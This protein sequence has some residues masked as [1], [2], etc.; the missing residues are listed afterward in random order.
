MVDC[1]C[2]HIGYCDGSCQHPKPPEI[3]KDCEVCCGEGQILEG[4][5]VYEE[6][7]GFSHPD[8]YEKPCLACNG[9]G[10]F[11]CEAEGEQ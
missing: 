7:C 10:V 4:I 2:Q 3:W 6:G 9:A 8:V 5:H 11:I 1:I